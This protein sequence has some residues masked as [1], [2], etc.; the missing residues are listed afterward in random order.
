MQ[1]PPLD[2]DVADTAPSDA[3]LILYDEEHIH[4]AAPSAD[5]G[6]RSPR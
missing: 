1:K 4:C 5:F 3:V 6:R 2:P